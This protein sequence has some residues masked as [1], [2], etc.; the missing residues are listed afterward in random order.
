MKK[1]TGQLV[2]RWTMLIVVV[3]AAYWGV[4]VWITGTMPAATTWLQSGGDHNPARFELP[5]SYDILVAAPLFALIGYLS[6]GWSGTSSTWWQR[7]IDEEVNNYD[8]SPIAWSLA[9][10]AVGAGTAVFIGLAGAYFGGLFAGVLAICAAVSWGGQN[11]KWKPSWLR[12]FWGTYLVLLFAGL[13]MFGLTA[14]LCGIVP[15][16]AYTLM[17]LCTSLVVLSMAGV[18]ALLAPPCR[19]F[20]D[21]FYRHMLD[22]NPPE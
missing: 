2:L 14:L 19:T 10:G 9:C 22:T 7:H 3:W 18:I 21:F 15:G 11:R 1:R 5:R 4:R 8:I 17:A 6:I 20:W 16:G 13:V 12:R